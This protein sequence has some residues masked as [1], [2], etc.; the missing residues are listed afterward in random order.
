MDGLKPVA[1]KTV[2]SLSN[3]GF[4]FKTVP[5]LSKRW[6]NEHLKG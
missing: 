4:S 5:S 6:L 1:F 2:A 3:H